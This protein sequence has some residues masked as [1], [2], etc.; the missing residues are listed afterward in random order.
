LNS[1]VRF[2]GNPAFGCEVQK[3]L[4]D[5][6]KGNQLGLA[7]VAQEYSS[8]LGRVNGAQ[9]P[10]EFWYYWR[11]FFKFSDTNQ[12]TPQEL[13]QVDVESFLGG[14]GAMESTLGK[15]L[16]MKGMI[17]NWHIPYLAKLSDRFFCVSARVP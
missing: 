15:P 2:F 14:L 9:A 16:A 10:S 6:D 7:N 5:F 11:R 13:G 17:M 1:L 12:L 8:T 3:A 4:V